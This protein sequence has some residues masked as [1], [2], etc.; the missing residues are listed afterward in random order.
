TW[1]GTVLAA[2]ALSEFSKADSAAAAKRNITRA[3]V[4]VAARLGNTAAICRKCYIHPE[5]VSAYLDGG[6]LLRVQN[7]IDEKLRHDVHALRPEAA[8]VLAFLR[9]RIAQDL[10]RR[11]LR[12]E[13]APALNGKTAKR[14]PPR[15]AAAPKARRRAPESFRGAKDQQGTGAAADIRLR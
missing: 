2:M 6:L 3:V 15:Q 7:E 9:S 11:S 13:A 14:K 8:A 12:T 10:D 4:Q 1:T 5:I